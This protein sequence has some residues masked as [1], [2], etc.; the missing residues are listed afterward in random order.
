MEKKVI[1]TGG[2][3]FIGRVLAGELAICGYEVIVLSRRPEKAIR[4]QSSRVHTAH[5][6]P[7]D[8]ESWMHH[9]SGDCA[10]VNLAGDNIAS[11]LRWTAAKKNRILGSRLFV[12]KAVSE[13]VKQAVHKPRVLI[14]ASAVGIYGNRYDEVLTEASVPGNGF[15]ADVAGQWEKSI[16]AVRDQGVRCVAIRTGIVLGKGG[17]FLERVIVPFRLFAGGHPGNGR[18][19]LSWIH[20]ADETQAIRFLIEHEDLNGCFNLTAPGPLTARDFFK[21]LGRV[22]KRPS[23]LHPP[24]FVLRLLFGELAQELLLSGQRVHPHRLLNAG[25]VFRYPD[26]FSALNDLLSVRSREK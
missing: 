7:E 12:G 5:W 24:A 14:Q 15:L 10:I 25:Y 20:L 23:W 13:A 3:G 9:L 4:H 1:I 19:W 16:S 17:G 22:T 21:T 2:S 6:N 11:S 8:P 18:Q 26:V